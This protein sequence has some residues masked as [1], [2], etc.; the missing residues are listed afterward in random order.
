MKAAL[1]PA[2]VDYLFYVAKS[3]GSHVFTRTNAEHER[4][5]RAIREGRL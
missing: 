5:K 4:A 2:G 1:N 3:D